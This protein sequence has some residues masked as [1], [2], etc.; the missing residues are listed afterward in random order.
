[1]F[2]RVVSQQPCRSVGYY[3]KIEG[4]SAI[5]RTMNGSSPDLGLSNYA[6]KGVQTSGETVPLSSKKNATELAEGERI[7]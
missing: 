5:L 4:A 7:F 6:K 1:M 2:I 3:Y